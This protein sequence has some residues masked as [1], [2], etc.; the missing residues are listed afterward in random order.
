MPISQSESPYYGRD[1]SRR[2]NSL[3]TAPDGA[4]DAYDL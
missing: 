1:C 2:R 3:T 4:P